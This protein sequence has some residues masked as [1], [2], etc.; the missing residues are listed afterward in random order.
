[1]C[2][3]YVCALEIGLT[4]DFMSFA[5]FFDEYIGIWSKVIS[6]I[7][8]LQGRAMSEYASNINFA[9]DAEMDMRT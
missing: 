7:Q 6:A 5:K 9:G 3:S 8:I 1:M 4:L 2:V